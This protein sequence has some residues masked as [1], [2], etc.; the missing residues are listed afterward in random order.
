MSESGIREFICVHASDMNRPKAC[1]VVPDSKK[2]DHSLVIQ[3]L[4]GLGCVIAILVIL[5][6]VRRSVKRELMSKMNDEVQKIVTQYRKLENIEDS[7]VEKIRKS[8]A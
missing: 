7:E 8:D 2:I 1:R 3:I 4:V 5:Y 6:C